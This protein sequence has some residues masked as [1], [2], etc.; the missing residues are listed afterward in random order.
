M[1]GGGSQPDSLLVA[2]LMAEGK[3]AEDARELLRF[4][5]GKLGRRQPAVVCQ[6]PPIVGRVQLGDRRRAWSRD[7]RDYRDRG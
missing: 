1:S 3:S 6:Q 4:V 2:A 5:A 7:R